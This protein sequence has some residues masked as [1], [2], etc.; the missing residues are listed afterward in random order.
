VS[1]ITI[2]IVHKDYALLFKVDP[3]LLLFVDNLSM[4]PARFCVD[5]LV[6]KSRDYF[7]ITPFSLFF[8]AKFI[9]LK[10]SNSKSIISS[11]HKIS[12]NTFMS[13]SFVNLSEL[14]FSTDFDSNTIFKDVLYFL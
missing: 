2:S 1:P 11:R 12:N 8:L 5:I 6:I 13:L 4:M 7:D 14:F 9:N 3:F 10:R